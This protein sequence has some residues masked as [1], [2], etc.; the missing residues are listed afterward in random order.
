VDLNWLA[1][2]FDISDGRA[3][4]AQFVGQHFLRDSSSAPKLRDQMSELAVEEMLIRFDLHGAQYDSR[5]C[6][7]SIGQTRLGN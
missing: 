3:R 1:A 2:F 4:E 5:L 6:D 7:M